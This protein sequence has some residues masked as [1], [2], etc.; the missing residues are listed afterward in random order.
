[1]GFQRLSAHTGLAGRTVRFRDTGVCE[2]RQAQLCTWAHALQKLRPAPAVRSVLAS[3]KGQLGIKGAGGTGPTLC[4]LGAPPSPHRGWAEEGLLHHLNR[5]ES[6]PL[7]S[8]AS[9]MPVAQKPL[10]RAKDLTRSL[11]PAGFL[12]GPLGSPD[13]YPKAGACAQGGPVWVGVSRSP[14]L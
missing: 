9:E 11:G 1:M 8:W 7:S 3:P 4:T 2:Q 12:S 5:P 13:Q 6:L 10:P 14:A